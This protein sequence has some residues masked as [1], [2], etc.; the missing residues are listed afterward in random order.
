MVG[1]SA[2]WAGSEATDSIEKG[3]YSRWIP[4]MLQAPVRLADWS[5]FVRNVQRE[6]KGRFDRWIFWENPDLDEAPQSLPP[7][8]YAAMLR[9]FQRWAKLYSPQA[10]VIAGGFN[11]D[12]A[13]GYLSRIPERTSCRSTRLPCR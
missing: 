10:K 7:E 12:K 2:D 9:M 3:T 4:N 6:Y 8:R 13:L 11:F 5:Q 1:F